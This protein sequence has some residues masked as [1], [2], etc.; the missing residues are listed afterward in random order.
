MLTIRKTTGSIAQVIAGMRDVPARLVPYAAST[1]LTRTAQIAAKKDLP[2]AMRAAFDRPTRYT[3]NSLFVRASTVETLSARVM[4][5]DQTSNGGTVAQDY[6]LPNVEGGGRKEKR[7]ERSLRYSGILPSGWRAITGTGAPLDAYGNL[8]SGEM[9]RMLSAVGG[10]FD[11]AQNRTKSKRSQRNAKNAPYFVVT[12]FSGGFSGGKYRVKPS[13]MQP[14]I[15][16][17]MGGRKILPALIFTATQPQYRK[18]LDFE[19][20]ALKAA[21]ENFETEFKRA[22]EEMRAKGKA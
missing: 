21:N 19:G 3:L 11:R 15:Y 12:P 14:G 7:F 18:R 4:V 13:I 1:A 17:R 22:F 9:Q 16:K 6:L 8:K 2:D 20:V 10:S 5:K